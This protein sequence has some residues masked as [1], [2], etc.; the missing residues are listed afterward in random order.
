M[1]HSRRS[2]IIADDLNPKRHGTPRARR[3]S[4]ANRES[5]RVSRRFG[6]IGGL[7]LCLV[8]ATTAA[9]T[10]GAPAGHA[11]QAPEAGAPPECVG[12]FGNS[13]ALPYRFAETG[14]DGE[15]LGGVGAAGR[16]CYRRANPTWGT[17]VNESPQHLAVGGTVSLSVARYNYSRVSGP[18]PNVFYG[19]APDLP[20][21]ANPQGA[22]WTFYDNFDFANEPIMRNLE[23]E[24]TASVYGYQQMFQIAPSFDMSGCR[25]P[26]NSNTDTARLVTSC[27]VKLLKGPYYKTGTTGSIPWSIFMG[28]GPFSQV[29][30]QEPQLTNCN[31]T[32]GPRIS[33]FDR[34]AEAAVLIQPS[35]YARMVWT[36]RPDDPLTFDFDGSG[37]LYNG[38]IDEYEWFFE[39]DDGSW[40][41]GQTGAIVTQDFPEVGSYPVRLRIRADGQIDELTGTVNIGYNA[42]GLSVVVDSPI[43][44]LRVDPTG[45]DALQQ[46]TVQITV[47]N[48]SN[49]PSQNVVLSPDLFSTPGRPTSLGYAGAAPNPSFFSLGTI[50]AESSVIRTITVKGLVE[51]QGRVTA[52]VSGGAK[53]YKNFTVESGC[54]S[55]SVAGA[56]CKTI[57]PV[58]YLT[59][60][61]G[62]GDGRPKFSF[63]RAP[64]AKTT[65]QGPNGVQAFNGTGWTNLPNPTPTAEL[66][67]APQTW[68]GASAVGADRSPIVDPATYN[69]NP[70]N[71][72]MFRVG[73][74]VVINPGGSNQEIRTVTAFGS[75]IYNQ[76][77]SNAHANGEMVS[78]LPATNAMPPD[79]RPAYGPIT[80]LSPTNVRVS[81]TDNAANESGYLVYRVVGSTQTL[82]PGCS[83][84]TPNLTQC[85][86]S[87]VSPGMLY[88]Y[89]VYAWNTVGTSFPG[90]YLLVRPPVTGLA[91]PTVRYAVAT[92]A[93]TARVAWDDNSS[94]E[95]GFKVYRYTPT[96]YILEATTGPNVTSATF[97]NPALNTAT[98]QIFVVSAFGVGTEI[99][100]DTYIFTLGYVTPTGN[101]VY[102]DVTPNTPTSVT[103][104]WSTTATGDETGY[105]VYR[106][107]GSTQTL[108]A[109]CPITD[110]RLRTCTDTGLTPG[111]FYQYHVFKWGPSG[112]TYPGT[113]LIA[114]TAKPLA[115]PTLIAATG[116][117]AS[118]IRLQWLDNA[119]DETGYQVLEYV[120]GAYSLVATL[121]PNTTTATVSGLTPNTTHIYLLVAIRST[122]T[123]YS[124]SPIWAATPSS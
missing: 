1:Q 90:T 73:D 61:A 67:I 31:G 100:G 87:G 35:P 80:P 30:N 52:E 46:A 17:A 12:Y 23:G 119:T 97:T 89:Y 77:L 39:A 24:I 47:S 11:I 42:G 120:L 117:T 116:A 4:K 98:P 72:P 106:V 50:A 16:L 41:R 54:R 18:T 20:A 19:W 55:E 96:G 8:A 102:A 57:P 79:A 58:D 95:T 66:A 68:T 27:N 85:I 28:W 91:G 115:A 9:I 81:W 84:T 99:Y 109:G 118:S 2:W 92:G 112:V 40:S 103:I 65:R 123:A 25:K 10:A 34:M 76:P 88:Q 29:L 38:T 56:N 111:T 94:T 48:S 113:G 69:G 49:Q 82:V 13:V 51:G 71:S 43:N 78:L 5:R 107:V 105:Q 64:D 14:D 45:T 108:V 83:T 75:L 26:N 59:P 37:S 53:G 3:G 114:R 63:S 6:R 21:V 101:T 93:S 110:D 7:L 104:N 60:F 70:A 86:D 22:A 74:T 32:C 44:S 62:G 36:A 15:G 33:R 121:A 124:A 122:D